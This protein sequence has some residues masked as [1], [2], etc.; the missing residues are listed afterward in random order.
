[1]KS[2][3]GG[4]IVGRG[5]YAL[6]KLRHFYASW[7]INRKIDRGRELPIKVVSEQL[8]HSSIRMTADR[9]GHLFPRGDDAAE[10]AAADAM[11][12]SNVP[13]PRP[14]MATVTTLRPH[15]QEVP[16]DALPPSPAPIQAR[17]SPVVAAE[18]KPMSISEAAA[19]VERA[20][21][22]VLA[23]PDLPSRALATKTGM[24][25][26]TIDLARQ[27]LSEN[28]VSV[29]NRSALG[30]FMPGPRPAP[31]L[32]RAKA[33]VL[34]EANLPNRALARKIG[35]T[36]KMIFLARVAL[37]VSGELPV[38]EPLSLQLQS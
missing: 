7:C 16:V 14:A 26:S 15:A 31:V 23:H 11:F 32:E 20:K 3:K 12:F 5:K 27:A 30:R 28:P 19:A 35:C 18:P 37:S 24:S 36:H 2:A 13:A 8:G 29:E 25:R 10:L 21:V 4:L 1:L 22:A 6:H 17:P 33:A 9:Y 34:A 38:A